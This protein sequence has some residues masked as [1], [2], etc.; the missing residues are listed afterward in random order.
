VA[1]ALAALL[2]AT[3]PSV[4]GPLQVLVPAYFYPLG[5]PYWGEMTTAAGSIN[6]TAI[7]NP[8]NGPGQS[9][10]SDYVT[11][12]NN[13]RAAGGHVIGYVYTNYGNRSEA[14][15]KADIQSYINF[16]HIDGIFLDQQSTDPA[17]VGY[18]QD[19]YSFI[20]GLNPSYEVIANPGTTTSEAYLNTPPTPTADVLVTFE[21]FA[22]AYPGAVPPSWTSNYSA[23]HFA[24]IIH[25]E[26]TVAGMLADLQLAQ[27]RNVGW[28]YVT[29]DPDAPPFFN[30]YDRLPS[31]W[32]QEVAAIAATAAPE[33]SSVWLL[34]TGAVALLARRRNKR[35]VSEEL[36]RI[37]FFS[38]CQTVRVCPEPSLLRN[39]VGRSM[40]GGAKQ[41]FN[42]SP[43][44]S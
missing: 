34:A 22:S 28:V 14:E 31:Y 16:Y 3:Q 37:Y 33:P 35:R 9:A 12:V 15:V 19:L 7:L 18:Y 13:L 17:K 10:N 11:A 42:F 5:N 41:S 4:A 20:K 21:N 43:S 38:G 6:L 32:D 8:A 1:A 39:S 27:Q 23:N 26:P 44:N 30:P 25:T 24:N 2:I 40:P 36:E 29:D